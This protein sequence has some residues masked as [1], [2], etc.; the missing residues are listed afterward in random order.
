M[1]HQMKGIG[2]GRQNVY[3]LISNIWKSIQERNNEMGSNFAYLL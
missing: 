1:P 3:L 2:N